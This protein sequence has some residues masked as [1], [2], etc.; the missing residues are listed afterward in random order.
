M[1]TFRSD[2]VSIP[3]SISR[4]GFH[5]GSSVSLG[6]ADSSPFAYSPPGILT[7]CDVKDLSKTILSAS[8][9]TGTKRRRRER[10]PI[11][12]A[13]TTLMC[14]KCATNRIKY[15]S[16]YVNY[17]VC[18]ERNED[19]FERIQNE[20]LIEERINKEISEVQTRILRLTKKSNELNYSLEDKRKMVEDLKQKI[21]RREHVW[22]AL[23]ENERS[24]ANRLLEKPKISQAAVNQRMLQLINKRKKLAGQLFV[25]IFP[26][27]RIEH[28]DVESLVTVTKHSSKHNSWQ[29]INSDDPYG[30]V[31]TGSPAESNF[32]SISDCVLNEHFCF[33]TL[34]RSL[35][36]K[37]AL[38]P[39]KSNFHVFA[40][41]SFLAQLVHL[42]FLLFSIPISVDLNP[43]ELFI[44]P[45]FTKTLLS[46]FLLNLKI[47]AILVCFSLGIPFKELDLSKPL[48][49]LLKLYE[50]ICEDM[51]KQAAD[52][53]SEVRP[54][55]LILPEALK[56]EIS[57]LRAALTSSEASDVVVQGDWVAL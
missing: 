40:G 52:G 4:V 42:L 26:L 56:K 51:G 17:Q 2:N 33:E 54:A 15:S 49:S 57:D 39:D 16:S 11:C 32:Y 27:A 53:T 14:S 43:N 35:T 45:V 46:N 24:L 48:K 23:E 34:H 29:L 25:W 30:T 19:L 21:K 37:D 18:C 12:T 20:T 50:K 1:R 9:A 31:P 13:F 3:I 22:K 55:S 7:R 41:L 10:C 5:T 8:N 38:V 36:P 47:T 44:Q 28:K 6:L